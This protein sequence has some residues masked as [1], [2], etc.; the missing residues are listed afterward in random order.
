MHEQ[1]EEE[2]RLNQRTMLNLGKKE[3]CREEYLNLTKIYW[4]RNL[5]M[6]EARDAYSVLMLS[7]QTIF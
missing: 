2:L 5:C 3:Y 6:T 4:Q 1:R 7:I